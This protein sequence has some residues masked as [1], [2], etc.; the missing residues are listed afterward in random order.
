MD[1]IIKRFWNGPE[2]SL[3]TRNEVAKIRRCSI[4]KLDREAWLLAGIA[5]IKDGSRCLYSK[6]AILQFL[7]SKGVSHAV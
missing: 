5:Y 4:A 7:E 2:D 3:Y 6:K 1:D